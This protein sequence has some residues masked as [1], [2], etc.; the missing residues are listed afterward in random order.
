[1][2]KV[3]LGTFLMVTI[4]VMAVPGPSVIFLVARTLEGGRSAG[5]V[6]LLG[7][8]SG[9]TLHVVVA[10]TGLSAAMAASDAAL[11]GLRYGGAGY[12]LLLGVRHLGSAGAGTSG[13]PGLE[14]APRNRWAL[15]WQAFVVDVLNPKTV[16]FFVAFLPQFV[17]PG[18]GSPA[19]SVGLLGM[20]VV[21]VAVA[22]DGSYVL[23]GSLLA[24]RGTV[25]H[26]SGPLWWLIGFVYLGLAALA[27]AG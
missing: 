2:S 21:L 3:E 18:T 7:L 9:L 4:A 26:R 6:S 5:V 27:L 1:M 16:L 15:F 24:R 11:A 8:E 20:S 22:C 19:A 13:G 17:D 12:L 14:P 25:A 23:M 10:A